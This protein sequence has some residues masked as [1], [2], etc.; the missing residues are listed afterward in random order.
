MKA[1]SVR[2]LALVVLFG[3]TVSCPRLSAQ[4]KE[5]AAIKARAESG[6]STSQCLLGVAFALGHGGPADTEQALRWLRLSAG[7]ENPAALYALGIMHDIGQGVPA[8][9]AE[10]DR[11]FQA[12]YAGHPS[13]A[14][15]PVHQ[16]LCEFPVRGSYSSELMA[17]VFR[18]AELGR[19]EA[20]FDLAYMYWR[21]VGVPQDAAEALKWYRDA[22]EQGHVLSQLELGERLSLGHPPFKVLMDKAE[23][24]KWLLRAASK[25]VLACATLAAF[26]RDSVLPCADREAEAYVFYSLVAKS[27]RPEGIRDQ[28]YF[29]W[30]AQV[31]L[32]ES[33]LRLSPGRL[34]IAQKK[35][36]QLW[37]EME[38]AKSAK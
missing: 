6:D 33:R 13:F 4:G 7:K 15:F 3:L 16:V 17:W 30:L 38:A 23:G 36:A 12:I 24:E 8:S 11:C 21:G 26:Y 14:V 37:K 25:N 5:L 32:L 35:I 9:K 10:A 1:R 28:D 22:A 27:D 18:A 2:I 29:E 20:K 19:A 31:E 34:Q